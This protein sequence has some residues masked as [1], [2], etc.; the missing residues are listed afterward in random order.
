MKKIAILLISIFLINFAYSSDLDFPKYLTSGKDTIGVI[1]TL[2]QATN[3][4]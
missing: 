3:R 1:F 4:Q 2:K